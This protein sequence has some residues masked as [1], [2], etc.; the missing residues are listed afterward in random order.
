MWSYAKVVRVAGWDPQKLVVILKSNYPPRTCSHDPPT[1]H[2]R[3]VRATMVNRA[4][5]LVPR[6]EYQIVAAR[7]PARAAG[8]PPRVPPRPG[9]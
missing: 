3:K 6:P 2:A 8:W 9:N 1:E 7:V 5:M 4:R